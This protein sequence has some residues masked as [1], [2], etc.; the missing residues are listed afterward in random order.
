MRGSALSIC[1]SQQGFLEKI[2]TGRDCVRDFWGDLIVSETH[3]TVYM[4]EYLYSIANILA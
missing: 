1:C 3:H 4:K 2:N